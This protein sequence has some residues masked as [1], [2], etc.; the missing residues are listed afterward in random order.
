MA[1][2]ILDAATRE[3]LV[4]FTRDLRRGT[5]GADEEQFRLLTGFNDI[6]AA[7]AIGLLLVAVAT[8]ASLTSQL[9]AALAIAA[10][11]WGLAEYFT[12][13]RRMAL[14]SILLLL[15]FV[16]AVLA[17][18]L[19]LLAGVQT[20]VTTG[21]PTAA[22][23]AA[24]LCGVGA[25]AVH[26]WRFRVPITVAAG[27]AAASLAVVGTGGG[28]FGPAFGLVGVDLTPFLFLLCGAAVF[29][30]AMWFDSHD[31]A[32]VTRRSDVAFWL[33]LLASPMLVHP[34]FSGTGLADSAGGPVAA[35]ITVLAFALLTLVALAIDRRALIV[36]ALGY[37]IYAVQALVGQG[38]D[39]SI[40]S[41]LG[42]LIIGLV[43]VLLSAAWRPARLLL[44]RILPADWRARLPLVVT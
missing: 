31:P 11:S 20:M 8:I 1:A 7:I 6:F 25:A 27:A 42:L 29:T 37:A 17:A 10:L 22:L 33:H 21:V 41:S 15:S 2:G 18:A 28:L 40:G 44:L 26:W 43:L 16:G 5:A 38:G 30:L 4:L 32:R 3:R 36:S 19:S 34:L 12:R 39:F 14:P 9:V 24:C 13:R 35:I 23:V